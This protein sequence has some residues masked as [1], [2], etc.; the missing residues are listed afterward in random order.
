MQC[1]VADIP[2]CS[3]QV[4]ASPGPD[5]AGSPA[6]RLDSRQGRATASP[7]PTVRSPMSAACSVRL[8]L[9]QFQL[10]RAESLHSVVGHPEP[11][12]AP[13]PALSTDSLDG[14]GGAASPGPALPLITEEQPSSPVPAHTEQ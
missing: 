5:R 8:T 13:A 9:C 12:P 14:M 1:A 10:L 3:V 2:D 6:R 7:Q 4:R 11:A